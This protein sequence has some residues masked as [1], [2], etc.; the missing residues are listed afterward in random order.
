MGDAD[1]QME[2]DWY[3]A[4]EPYCQAPAVV[5]DANGADAPWSLGRNRV[6]Q[7]HCSTVN[8]GQCPHFQAGRPDT[9][10]IDQPKPR[11]SFGGLLSALFE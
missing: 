4:P 3:D 8:N 5:A 7:V 9:S 2:Y 1:W 6:Y 10:A 11:C